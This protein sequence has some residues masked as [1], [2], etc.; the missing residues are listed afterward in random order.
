MQTDEVIRTRSGAPGGKKNRKPSLAM[1]HSHNGWGES[2]RWP[3]GQ[4]FGEKHPFLSGP[5][6]GPKSATEAVTAAGSCAAP[7]GAPRAADPRRRRAQHRPPRPP[8]EGGSEPSGEERP[9][10]AR[11][12]GTRARGSG[13][14]G[15]RSQP[16][17]TEP[18][19]TR[20]GGAAAGAARSRSPPAARPRGRCRPL[21]ALAL[22]APH[23]PPSRRSGP[24]GKEGGRGQRCPITRPCL[25]PRPPHPAANGADQ[26]KRRRMRGRAAPTT[27]ARP[28]VALQPPGPPLPA[29]RVSRSPAGPLPLPRY[30]PPARSSRGAT[31]STNPSHRRQ[32]SP[33][34]N[35]AGPALHPIRA[36]PALAW[37]SG[38]GWS[39]GA[40][41]ERGHR[42]RETPARERRWLVT[43][44]GESEQG[45]GR[46]HVAVP[47]S[48][49][50]GA[51]PS[52]VSIRNELLRLRGLCGRGGEAVT[53][54]GS[55][56]PSAGAAS[57][58][59]PARSGH[60]H[61]AG[62]PRGPRGGRAGAPAP[63]G[64]RGRRGWD[65]HPW[66][67]GREVAARGFPVLLR[68]NGA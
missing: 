38:P 14:G 41:P 53:P 29:A 37:S 60:R 39:P 2:H 62:S 3:L 11:P 66:G 52:G 68:D 40:S 55:P 30:L 57:S 17:H 5:R 54:P 20:G 24:G 31:H 27:H 67:G 35:P 16:P 61:S 47:L 58:R 46:A 23:R 36:P 33:G 13:E 48:L 49:S 59:P 64:E 4:V 19:P 65:Q 50:R 43:A 18:L 15:R 21:P 56:Q 32:P 1:Q 45:T 51:C 6:P 42:T 26:G 25:P 28:P 8:R 44:P 22:T 7:A 10:T 34:E 12:A 63:C 9:R